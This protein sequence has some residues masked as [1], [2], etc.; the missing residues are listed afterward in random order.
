MTFDFDSSY[1]DVNVLLND[2]DIRQ[3]VHNELWSVDNMTDQELMES[4]INDIL[5]ITIWEIQTGDTANFDFVEFFKFVTL[6]HRPR[7]TAMMQ[8]NEIF[9][10]IEEKWSAEGCQ[11]RIRNDHAVL[12]AA[13]DFCG[14]YY[15]GFDMPDDVIIINHDVL[16]EKIS[17]AGGIDNLAAIIAMDIQAEEYGAFTSSSVN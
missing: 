8:R 17:E 9:G 15:S 11:L 13:M 5:F 10:L 2:E 12:Q 4:I 7:I 16:D 1:R 6:E 14:V 3:V